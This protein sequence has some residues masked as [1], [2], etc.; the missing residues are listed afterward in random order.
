MP[1]D[2]TQDAKAPER[3]EDLICFALYSAGHAMT[4]AYAPHLKSLGLTYPQYIL[5]TA[6]WD[7]DG[8]TNKDLCTKLMLDPGTLTPLVKRLERDGLVTRSRGKK[9]ERQV[10]VRLTA[11][12]HDLRAQAPEITKCI[13]DQTGV[14]VA[15]LD[16]LLRR[17]VQLRTNLLAP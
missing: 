14:P 9:D 2:M 12:G 6:L 5:L 13:I 16:D 15:E 4:R 8:Q 7:Q 11:R 17:L 10:F 1:D 3:V